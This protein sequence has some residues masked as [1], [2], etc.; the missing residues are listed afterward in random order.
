MPSPQPVGEFDPA[1]LTGP[2][3]D[4]A[5]AAAVRRWMVHD[6]DPVTR[7]ELAALVEAGDWA[8][9]GRRFAGRL[10]FGTA[11]LRAE[12]GAGPLRM[13]RLVVRQAAAG[14]VRTLAAH[15]SASPLVVVGYDARHNSDVFA[16][17]T[18]GVVAAAGGR[19]VLF[20]GHGPTPLL[21][22]A[23]RHL[24]ADAGVMVTASHNPPADN[25]YK[26][27]LADGAQIVPPI[28]AEIAA[29]I[30]DA[31]GA[32]EPVPVAP[33]DHP[34]IGL[35]DPAVLDAYLEV[36]TGQLTT[37]AS[38][39]TRTLRA[40]YTP[41]HGVGAELA[42][43]AFA[44]AGFPPLHVVAAQADPDPD[45]PTV[46]FPNPEE[47]GA[48]DLGL[49]LAREV[50]AD[51]LLANDPDADRLGV[52]IPVRASGDGAGWRA[53]TGNEIGALLADHLLRRRAG[54][55][56]RLVVTTIV[57]SR[58][59]RRIA[60]EHG[61]HYAETLTGFKWIVRPALDHPE[62]TF[63]FGYEEALGYSV[64]PAVRDKD[65]IAAALVFAELVAELRAAGSS[66]PDRLEEL[67]RRHGLHATV[68]W[69]IRFAGQVGA[70]QA[71]AVMDRVRSAP[72]ATLAGRRRL[73]A[74]DHATRP[75]VER[76]DALEWELEGDARIV[77]RPSGTEPKLK[78]YLE[79]VH[80]APAAQPFPAVEAA[81]A[82]ELASVRAAIEAL[83]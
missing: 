33:A 6:P 31:A 10:H 15:G 44:A 78:V 49:A 83:V 23:V 79:L 24:R 61:V 40:A 17:D 64:G 27:Y 76:T 56:Q 53:L 67:A 3:G 52:A 18:A 21:A 51:V 35:L 75:G 14:L 38:P 45:F 57:S 16:R 2:A 29:R 7:A 46:A 42:G 20:A 74:V 59:L 22:F 55:A 1:G 77:F 47:P 50:D 68:G 62:R 30:A 25:G 66:V 11:G 36:L 48:L 73:A 5:L 80:P 54:G 72:P 12:L 37:V 81:A 60:A 65:G 19:A 28:D 69:S 82:A 43:R 9:L 34:A 4:P 8:E 41:L 26:V 39:A 63:V 70:G 32:E 71:A 13:N 58:L